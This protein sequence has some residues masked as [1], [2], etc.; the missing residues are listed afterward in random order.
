MMMLLT[1]QLL[2]PTHCI[3]K[4]GLFL[5]SSKGQ[6]PVYAYVKKLRYFLFKVPLF[7]GTRSKNIYFQ[8]IEDL[9]I[10]NNI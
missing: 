7:L 8:N 10:Y 4:P 5:R 6:S 1:T 3:C 9:Q 2:I